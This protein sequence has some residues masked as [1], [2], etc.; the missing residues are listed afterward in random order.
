[1]TEPVNTAQL[2][3]LRDLLGDAFDELISTF[4]HE[5]QTHIKTILAAYDQA[6]N[7]LGTTA[8]QS[9]KG[10]SA[11]L[12]ATDLTTFCQN[13]VLECKAN[14]I[15]HSDVLV[16]NVQEELHRVNHFLKLQTA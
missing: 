2:L 4:L 15:Q 8:A 5:S 12:G 13:L 11:N 10:E 16:Q 3:E 9:L 14:R 7:T 6:N 1:M